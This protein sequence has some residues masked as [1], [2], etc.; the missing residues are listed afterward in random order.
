MKKNYKIFAAFIIF[1]FT[2][3][4]SLIIN[5]SVSKIENEFLDKP[6]NFLIDEALEDQKN[7]LHGINKNLEKYVRMT[8]QEGFDIFIDKAKNANSKSLRK[9]FTNL[10]SFFKDEEIDVTAVIDFILYKGSKAKHISDLE[11][12]LLFYSNLGIIGKWNNDIEDFLVESASNPQFNKEVWP[13]LEKGN[14]KRWY[15]EG[16]RIAIVPPHNFPGKENENSITISDE[17]GTTIY[18]KGINRDKKEIEKLV[19]KEAGIKLKWKDINEAQNNIRLCAI[20][21]LFHKQS[22]KSLNALRSLSKI[23][24]NNLIKSSIDFHFKI[25]EKYGSIKKYHELK[26]VTII[27]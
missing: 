3:I 4:S 24:S 9:E 10:L 21:A 7:I 5:L 2:F 26:Q 23:E 14:K 19:F 17:Q 1:M 22:K 27:E 8:G 12:C 11:S 6:A 20:T 16:T 13:I 25:L 18:I 15:I